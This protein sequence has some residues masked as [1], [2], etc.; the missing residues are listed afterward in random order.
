[1]DPHKFETFLVYIVSL[2]AARDIEDNIAST[3]HI[4][5]HIP[6]Y[7]GYVIR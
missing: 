2:R 3:K 7:I 4:H 6:V 1:M 5:A